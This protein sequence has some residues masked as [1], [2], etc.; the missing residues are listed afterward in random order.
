VREKSVSC[1]KSVSFQITVHFFFLNFFTFPFAE[2]NAF[3]WFCYQ[4]CAMRAN[5]CWF[6]RKTE[7]ITE[8]WTIG[9]LKV[10]FHLHLSFKFV[11]IECAWMFLLS[12]L[13]RCFVFRSHFL[14]RYKDC[15]G[16]IFKVGIEVSYCRFLK[17]ILNLFCTSSL[18]F[19]F[20]TL[21]K[22]RHC[23]LLFCRAKK[24]WA[25]VVA[26]MMGSTIG[27]N[28]LAISLL[29]WFVFVF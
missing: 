2:I 29:I 8:I 17:F 25:F 7:S 24:L 1:E 19:I 6:P 27:M 4:S 22:N 10:W 23:V 16:L 3:P 18:L 28:L 9:D 11:N 13:C 5:A 14:F 12:M 20:E 21:W 15:D 26:A